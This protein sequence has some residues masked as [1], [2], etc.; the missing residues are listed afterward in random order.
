[1]RKYQK[2]R[3]QDSTMKVKKQINENFNKDRQRITYV[4]FIDMENCLIEYKERTHKVFRTGGA[5]EDCIKSIHKN[6]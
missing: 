6:G 3:V 4:C 2:K 1:M 5:G